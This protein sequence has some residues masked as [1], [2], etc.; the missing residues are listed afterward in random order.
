MIAKAWFAPGLDFHKYLE[1]IAAMAKAMAYIDAS[2]APMPH[3]VGWTSS[4]SC[5][6]PMGD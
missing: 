6:P 5:R 3:G 2:H 1:L 4:V